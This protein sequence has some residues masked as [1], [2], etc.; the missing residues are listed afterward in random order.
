[1]NARCHAIVAR[2]HHHKLIRLTGECVASNGL[3]MRNEDR[4]RLSCRDRLAA[5]R[6][7]SIPASV[8]DQARSAPA[9]ALFKAADCQYCLRQTKQAPDSSGLYRLPRPEPLLQH[10]DVIDVACCVD[11][12]CCH[13]ILQCLQRI[14]DG[15]VAFTQPSLPILSALKSSRGSQIL[16]ATT[17]AQKFALIS[18]DNYPSFCCVTIVGIAFDKMGKVG[19]KQP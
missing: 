17:W 10:H 16:A 18:W 11:F 2:R 13:R 19:L 1:M 5:S 4:M 9:P 15:L 6:A 3:G 7:P 8:I 14:S 12:T